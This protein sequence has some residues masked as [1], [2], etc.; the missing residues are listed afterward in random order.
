MNGDTATQYTDAF[1]TFRTETRRAPQNKK[2][3]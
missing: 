1:V 2:I 3:K